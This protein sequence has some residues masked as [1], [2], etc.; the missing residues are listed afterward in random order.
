MN[1]SMDPCISEYGLV[2]ANAGDAEAASNP[3]SRVAGGAEKADVYSFGIIIL[4]LL[5]GKPVQNDPLELARWVDSVVREEWTVEVF[6]KSII[7]GG[8]SEE[9]MVQMLQVGLR[10]VN[11]SAKAR[12][13]M[14]QVA[15]MINAVREEDESSLLVSLSD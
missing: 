12:P 6:D 11:P 10:C 3:I 9:R 5:T 14:D 4:E 13:S 8:A 2:V 7:S 15:S 1:A